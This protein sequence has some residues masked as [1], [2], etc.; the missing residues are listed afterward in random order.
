[1]GDDAAR[2]VQRASWVLQLEFDP[3]RGNRTMDTQTLNALLTTTAITDPAAKKALDLGPADW[4][5]YAQIELL[6]AGGMAVKLSVIVTPPPEAKLPADGAQ[7]FL[8]ELTA[9]ARV[10]VEQATKRQEQSSAE[11]RTALEKELATAQERLAKTSAQLREARATL[12]QDSGDN[13]RNNARNLANEI[14]QLETNLIGQRARLR[15]VEDE[16]ERLR[17]VS[18][19]TRPSGD[20]WRD[21]IAAH[22]RLVQVAQ[23]MRNA[24][25]DAST[26][27][28]IAQAQVDLAA[29]RVRAAT[30]PTDAAPATYNPVERWQAERIQLKGSI[31]ES[32]ARLGALT[33]RL[34]GKAN[35]TTRAA[36]VTQYDAD[37]LAQEEA[38][39]RNE[40]NELMQQLD[41]LRRERRGGGAPTRLIVLDGSSAE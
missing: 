38:R 19:A 25:A 2:G 3:N 34:S 35:P 13:L 37:Q 29:A 22:E 27:M 16:A 7:R 41:Q 5:K 33:E 21:Y 17:A 20:I 18:P 31:A 32:E 24:G 4:P 9:R 14:Q 23:A 26:D 10:A 39:A 11:R 8:A 36:V 28:R 1:V 15:V 6:P 12:V 40:V 30:T